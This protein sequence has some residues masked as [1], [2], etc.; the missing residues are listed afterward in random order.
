MPLYGNRLKKFFSF[1]KPYRV[2]FIADMLCALAVAATALLLPLCTRS[3][4]KA[5]MEQGI[6]GI[7][8][9]QRSTTVIF[10][11][12]L[13]ML[14]LIIVQTACGLFQDG[15]G[16]VM[17]AKIERN[18][19]NELFAHYQRLPFSFFDKRKTGELM[20]RITNDLINLAELYHHGP[21]DIVI[22][23]FGFI[24]ALLILLNI[25]LKLALVVS[26][27]LPVM[28]V[29][30]LFFQKRLRAAYKS[31]YEKIAGVNAQLEDS[32]AGIRT[33]KSFAGEQAEAE[34]FAAIN[35]GFYQSRARIYKH[36]A[37]YYTGMET[38]FVPLVTAAVVVFGGMWISRTSLDAADL[39]VFLL[40][41]GYITAPIQR[42]AHTIQQYQDGFAGFNRFMDIMDMP[43]EHPTKFP[44]E[45][46]NGK[47][48]PTDVKGRVEFVNVSFKYDEDRENI[49][50][51]F[52][53]DIKAGKMVALVGSSGVGKTTLCSL[54][55][56]FYEVNA[57]AILLDGI[58]VRD[59]SLQKLRGNIGVVQQEVYLFAGTVLENIR[60][61]KPDADEAEV[62]AA[63][64]KA[65]AH[66]FIM[67]LPEGYQSDIGQ[68]GV[69]LSGGQR[70]RLS[71]ARVFLKNPPVLIFDEATSALDNESERIVHEALNALAKDRTT[72]II[73]HRLSTVRNADRILAL[74][75]QGIAEQGN[76]DEL[77]LHRGI[78][79]RL[80]GEMDI[81]GSGINDRGPFSSP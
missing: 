68:R 60:Y 62:I 81:S 63:A 50:D 19:R 56:R 21:E 52:S 42:I 23:L 58:D 10:T 9:M 25:N 67:E 80:V 47:I 22:I 1:Y 73:A 17:G 2:L 64:K 16:H 30:S 31:S 57:G 29:Y 71:I 40:Y 18:M 15:M 27:F 43:P 46:N 32:L 13:I 20:S 39:I 26:A 77:M 37:V 4:T 48:D 14:A 3:I 41:V 38:F 55:P 79:A 12:G 75:P 36:E 61:G 6:Q 54:I 59:I 74:T 45:N 70:Q 66:G 33:V 72:I 53:L 51:N 7:P 69:K 34:K 11:T 65:H 28:A 49:L 78:Y 44:P 5:V 8:G 76:H 35:E 24:G